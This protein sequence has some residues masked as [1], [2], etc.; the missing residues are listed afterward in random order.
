MTGEA[1]KEGYGGG[2]KH[3]DGSR[4]GLKDY[5]TEK[6]EGDQLEAMITGVD[7]IVGGKLG[8]GGIKHHDGLEAR[9]ED[10]IISNDISKG[11]DDG[12]LG[13]EFEAGKNKGGLEDGLDNDVSFSCHSLIYYAEC[14]SNSDHFFHL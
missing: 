13:D 2:G 8:L 11:L 5:I 12:G 14:S 9:L 10:S 4:A 3:D 7:L 6:G 1:E